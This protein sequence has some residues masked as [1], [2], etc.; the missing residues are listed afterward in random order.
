MDVVSAKAVEAQEELSETIV[1][2]LETLAIVAGLCVV[3]VVVPLIVAV[4]ACGP[5]S[6]ANRPAVRV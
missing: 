5:L 6:P 1:D 4:R 2:S 3:F